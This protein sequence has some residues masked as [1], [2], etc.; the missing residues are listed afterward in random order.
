MLGAAEDSAA[1]RALLSDPAAVAAYDRVPA[2]AAQGVFTLDTATD[3][4]VLHSGQAV[5]AGGGL[6][7]ATGKMW[8][9]LQAE[10]DP[11][12]ISMQAVGEGL[13][14]PA[15]AAAYLEGPSPPAVS[16]LGPLNVQGSLEGSH[17]A[18]IS[19]VQ[20]LAPRAGISGSALL[21][22]TAVSALASGPGFELQG[23]AA[24]SVPGADR[25]RNANSQVGEPGKWQHTCLKAR[26]WG[27]R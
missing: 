10:A 22:P 17:I 20:W 14:L 4:F 3:M 24:T 2:Q 18:P 23:Q 21:G 5:P 13:S 9:A 8:V 26:G 12:A 11:R 27:V 16:L 15:L 25:V 6:L 19:R 7:V 1:L